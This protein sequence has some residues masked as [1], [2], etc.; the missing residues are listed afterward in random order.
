MPILSLVS[1]T[2]RLRR[3]TDAAAGRP[4][5]HGVLSATLG[6]IAA[7]T[8]LILAAA[9]A[10]PAAS[11]P[12]PHPAAQDGTVAAQIDRFL[13]AQLKDSAIP[14]AAVA[15]TRG[16]RVLLVRGYGHDSTDI[17]VS[18]DSLFRIAS[19][20]KS[21][22]ALAVMQLVDAGLVDLDDPVE[23]HLPAFKMAD[24][25]AG[26]VTVRE[27]LD[28][29]SGITDALVADLSRVQP[30]NP[31]EAT[32]SLRSARL[33]TAP[34]TTYS[35]A[36]PNY[37]VAARLVEVLSGEPFD[38]YLNRHI[39]EPAGMSATTSTA[40]DD[41]PVPGL[42][43][44]HLIAYGHAFT[45]PAYGL[46]TTGDGGVVS[47]AADMARWLIVHTNRGRT[48]D[49]TPIVSGRGLRLLH[50][51][52]APKS[53]Y[54][55][56]WGTHGPAS[57]PTRVEH[58]GNLFRFTS[59]QALW[60]ASGYG[61]VLLFNSGSPMMLDQTAIVHGVFDIVEGNPPPLS[62]PHVA[63]R[64]DAVLAVLTLATLALGVCGV[65]R[66]G[67][68]VR[69]RRSTPLLALLSVLPAALVLGAGAAFPGLAEAWTRRDVT[70]QVVAYEW[71]A[72]FVFVAAALIAAA[73]TL[74]ARSWRWWRIYRA[75]PPSDA[76]ARRPAPNPGC[77]R[78]H[79]TGE[80][81]RASSPTTAPT[82][83]AEPTSRSGPTRRGRPT[84]ERSDADH[85]K[86]PHV[87]TD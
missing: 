56:G 74:L 80:P 13:I 66:A 33:A 63:A 60:P 75:D 50:T 2:R 11:A 23:Q 18:G 37:Q 7:T 29:T 35:Y 45:A 76:P 4:G 84:H 16:N 52:S 53:G 73:G 26:Q 81:T 44:G 67:R 24:P 71:P 82:S 55:L 79:L 25:R 58:S 57:D 14:G 30:S 40:T 28:H 19:L 34:G 39:F 20:S 77:D 62:G 38:A 85:E 51:P 5:S 83:P 17:P 1:L 27:L 65:S 10:L 59:E 42:T 49:G 22:T 12:H 54:A 36:N 46:Y 15:V 3:T 47:S 70:Y 86:T 32:T 72:L 69:R 31:K 68:W 6:V 41:Q 8:A 78:R 9:P 61:V 64:I 21:F 43:A 87:G 48:A